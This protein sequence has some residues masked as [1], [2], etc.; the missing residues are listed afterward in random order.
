MVG[1]LAIQ[2]THTYQLP[3]ELEMDV[4][5]KQEGDMRL[6]FMPNEVVNNLSENG[7]LKL[8]E[9]SFRPIKTEGF[10]Y[11][12]DLEQKAEEVEVIEAP[13]DTTIKFRARFEKTFAEYTQVGKDGEEVKTIRFSTDLQPD[14]ESGVIVFQG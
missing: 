6:V 8:P 5:F 11:E 9:D 14:Q 1:N 4:E 2:S 7:A 13:L 12:E 10:D 3:V